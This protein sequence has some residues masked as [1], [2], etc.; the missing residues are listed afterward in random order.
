MAT[1]VKAKR[2]ESTD[3]VIKRFKKRALIDD[4][5]TLIRDK[6]F[7]KKPAL[8]RKEHKKELER[9]AYRNKRIAAFG[10]SKKFKPARKP[11]R[12]SRPTE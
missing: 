1:I 6:E 8:Q 2:D 5:L 7:Y 4:T 9:R 3:N 10:K 12:S 11:V